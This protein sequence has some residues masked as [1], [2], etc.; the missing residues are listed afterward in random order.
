MSVWEDILSAAD[1][2]RR[3]TWDALGL[4]ETG[5]GLVS[6][7]TGMDEDS[8]WA[9]ALG[10]GAEVL[11]DP[12][13]LMLGGLGGLAAKAFRGAR[14]AKSA[15]DVET[16]VNLSRYALPELE[17]WGGKEASRAAKNLN[18]EAGGKYW[19]EFFAKRDAAKMEGRLARMIPGRTPEAAAQPSALMSL[20]NDPRMQRWGP[21]S[22]A[23]GAGAGVGRWLDQRGVNQA[24][25]EEPQE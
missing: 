2:P 6:K 25:P 8:P 12:S 9:H 24:A 14:A 11:G 4:P 17:S 7:Y 1:A 16:V 23:L 20:L 5:A 21:R 18:L 13:V 10:A 22:F 19:P 3:M 15:K